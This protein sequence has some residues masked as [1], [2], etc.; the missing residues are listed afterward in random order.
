LKHALIVSS[1]VLCVSAYGAEAI[2]PD[3]LVVRETAWRAWFGADEA[4]LRSI[5]PHDFAAIS[6]EGSEV[7]DREKTIASSR[8][9]KESGGHLISL[10]FPRTEAQRFGD[11]VILYGSYDVTFVS[12]GKEKRMRGRLTEVFVKRDGTWVHPGWHLDATLSQ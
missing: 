10:A 6:T 4:T 2:D 11:T 7:S 8:A 1:V 12:S 5:L 9:F 3:V